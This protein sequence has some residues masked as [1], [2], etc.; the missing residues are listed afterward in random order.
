M[1]TAGSPRE[2]ERPSAALEEAGAVPGPSL[3][4]TGMSEGLLGGW[5]HFSGWCR[6]SP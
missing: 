1:E 4:V 2:E 5:A 3:E 6:V